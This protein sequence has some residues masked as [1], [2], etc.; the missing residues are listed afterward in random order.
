MT[1]SSQRNSKN[2]KAAFYCLVFGIVFLLF[3]LQV[4]QIRMDYLKYWPSILIFFGIQLV[5]NYIFYK[6]T[7]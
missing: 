6:D 3:N 5:L 1:V 4:I 7:H 2:L